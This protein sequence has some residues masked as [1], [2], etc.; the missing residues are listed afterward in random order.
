MLQTTFFSASYTLLQAKEGT[1]ID[2]GADLV[3]APLKLRNNGAGLSL[4]GAHQQNTSAA[5]VQPIDFTLTPV[6]LQPKSLSAGA[7]RSTNIGDHD[8]TQQLYSGV[9]SLSIS[10]ESVLISTPTLSPQ[11]N[12]NGL[13]L[14]ASSNGHTSHVN[15]SN[16]ESMQISPRNDR[17]DL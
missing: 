12:G 5:I 17:M 7:S 8:D 1:S 3:V 16:G 14:G 10:G 6:S 13:H 9:H 11:V 2:V 4:T 15:S